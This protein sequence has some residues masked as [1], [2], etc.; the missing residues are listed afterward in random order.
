M[1]VILHKSKLKKVFE[2]SARLLQ[3]VEQYAPIL[4]GISIAFQLVPSNKEVA[5]LHIRIWSPT[6]HILQ[7]EKP[8]SQAANYGLFEILEVS[9]SHC[10]LQVCVAFDEWVGK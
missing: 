10:T 2:H 4:L 6:N 5:F 3:Y 8:C 9:Y 1:K 7:S